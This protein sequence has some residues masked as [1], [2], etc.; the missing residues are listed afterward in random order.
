MTSGRLVVLSSRHRPHELAFQALSLILGA[1]Y[2]FGAPAPN[3]V[4]ALMPAWAVRLWA[5]GLLVSGLLTA[6]SLLVRRRAEVELR[7]EQAAMLFGAGA[8]VWTTYAIFAYA[9]STRAFFAGGFCLAWATANVIRA[10]Q[11]RR[12]A[13]RVA[14]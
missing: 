8:L 1:V 5:G 10:E 11:C 9:P 14:P 4:A 3:S 12:D 2:L 6:V 7:I 13:R